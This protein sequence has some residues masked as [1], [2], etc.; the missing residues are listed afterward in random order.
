M[1]LIHQNLYQENNLTGV[2]V[3]DYIDQLTRNLFHSCNINPEQVKLDIQSNQGTAITL[4][5]PNYKTV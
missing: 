2:D 3:A 4:T 1:A 5:T